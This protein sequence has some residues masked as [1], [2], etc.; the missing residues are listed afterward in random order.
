[1]KKRI[2]T[3]VWAA[4]LAISA[5]L[6]FASCAT[7]ATGGSE[8]GSLSITGLPEELEGENVDFSLIS[9]VKND[10][11]LLINAPGEN[12][13]NPNRRMVAVT[14][15]EVKLPIYTGKHRLYSS[16]PSAGYSGSDT[17]R[18]IIMTSKGIGTF[19]KL[20]QFQNGTAMVEWPKTAVAQAAAPQPTAAPEPSQPVSQPVTPPDED[21][22]V[23]Q[24]SDGKTLTISKYK[25]SFTNIIIP[26]KLYGL[27]VTVI[28]EGAFKGK[29][30]TNVI[31][32]EG[33]I[34]IA[35]GSMGSSRGWIYSEAF[36]DNE[37]TSVTIPNS[38][39]RIGDLAFYENK[40][41]SVTIG[42]SVTTIGDHVF[43]GNQLT[44]VVIPDSV[45]SIGDDAFSSNKLTS[46]ALGNRVATIGNGAFQSNQLTSITIPDSV[47][48][49]GLN[50]FLDNRLTSVTLGRGI[51]VIRVGAFK[52]NQLT[53][54]TIKKDKYEIQTGA[55]FEQNFV[56]FYESQGR[57]PGTY[58]KNGPIWRKQ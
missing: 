12:T 32:P 34:T 2:I 41:T 54:I 27:P 6:G 58:V 42:N 17:F 35:S 49:I 52:N 22:E 5:A 24:N 30:L 47:T 55:G 38:V 29:G 16:K 13:N 53:S 1:M 4:A 21:F 48:S 7:T 23:I 8:P 20:V 37:L 11:V 50:A 56:N 40:L 44:S 33:V 28:G 45:T 14:N 15:G 25:G 19:E 18:I 9:S 57:T 3:R 26:A 43:V 46:L 39:T 51:R 10:A 36:A 31:I